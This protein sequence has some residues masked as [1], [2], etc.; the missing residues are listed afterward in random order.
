MDFSLGTNEIVD[1]DVVQETNLQ[2]IIQ[3][4]H[5]AFEDSTNSVRE[6]IQKHAQILDKQFL[7]ELQ[8]QLKASQATIANIFA[9]N[10]QSLQPTSLHLRLN[11]L[12]SEKNEW[13]Q[14]KQ[15]GVEMLQQLKQRNQ[16]L[17]DEL[18]KTWN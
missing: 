9:Q 2:I 3:S 12:E 17:E 11:Q 18:K 16:Q 6:I 10:P 7:S 1:P 4:L 14:Q 5:S 15:K 8:N 13:E